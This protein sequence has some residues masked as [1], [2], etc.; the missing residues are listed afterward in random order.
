VLLY[1]AFRQALSSNAQAMHHAAAARQPQAQA[2][3]AHS[4][5]LADALLRVPTIRSHHLRS[6]HSP[7]EVERD[8]RLQQAGGN[9]NQFNRHS[10]WEEQRRKQHNMVP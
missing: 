2:W 9:Y 1:A 10:L 6:S 8:D 3:L 5:L 4:I 7:A